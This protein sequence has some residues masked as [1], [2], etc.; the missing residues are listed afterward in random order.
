MLTKTRFV[1]L[2]AASVAVAIALLLFLFDSRNQRPSSA[3]FETTAPSAAGQPNATSVSVP[4]EA[5]AELKIEEA[6][7][8][9][10]MSSN[11]PKSDRAPD[12][13]SNEAPAA[14]RPAEPPSSLPKKDFGTIIGTVHN[15]QME[16]VPGHYVSFGRH[17]VQGVSRILAARTDA[18]GSYSIERVSAGEWM[19]LYLGDSGESD[20]A[21]IVGTVTVEKNQVA[22]F[23]F[24]LEGDRVLKGV[25][26]VPEHDGASLDLELRDRSFQVVA[27]GD[28]VT[29]SR[30]EP[31]PG[32]VEGPPPTDFG[33]GYFR[34]C[35]LRPDQYVLRIIAGHKPS[36]G[37]PMYIEEEIDL[38]HGDVTLPPRKFTYEEF[39]EVSLKRKFPRATISVR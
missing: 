4:S 10:S 36:T 24:A 22:V 3:S 7:S 12:E 30:L 8:P 17:A 39:M 25:L 6:A 29:N 34:F 18:A 5:S 27:R 11:T 20:S 9:P 13:S 23:N 32:D 26:T 19:A 14:L 28:A 1:A 15:S 33:S 37:E 35:G 16:P 21:L 31:V 2:A 38:T